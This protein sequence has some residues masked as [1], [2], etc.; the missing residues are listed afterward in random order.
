MARRQ[1]WHGELT[2]EQAVGTDCSWCGGEIEAP[3][4]DRLGAWFCS[5]SHRDQ[6]T[7]AVKRLREAEID[8]NEEAS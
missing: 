5:R 2:R 7:A 1:P 4:P 3:F 6:S 8:E